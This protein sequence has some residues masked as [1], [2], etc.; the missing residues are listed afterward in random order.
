M[1]E[2]RRWDFKAG[3][4]RWF[5]GRTELVG[6]DAASKGRLELETKSG[7]DLQALAGA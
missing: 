5:R 2:R 3:R 1:G 7:T 4:I 6:M